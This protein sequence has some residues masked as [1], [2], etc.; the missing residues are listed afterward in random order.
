MHLEDIEIIEGNTQSESAVY[1]DALQR[2]INSGDAWKLQGSYGRTM[3]SA[4]EEGF[5]LLG[6]S[7]AEDAYG[8]RIPSRDDVQSGTKGSRTFV[9]ARQG[10]AWAARMERLGC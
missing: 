10:E 3:M 8:S 2:A 9:A 4:I 5:C 1:Y 7:P 6:P